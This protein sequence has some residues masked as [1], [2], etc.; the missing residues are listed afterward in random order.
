MVAGVSLEESA[1]ASNADEEGGGGGDL[2]P[3]YEFEDRSNPFNCPASNG[4][5]LEIRE[6]LRDGTDAES[7]GR[8]AAVLGEKTRNGMLCTLRGYG[9]NRINRLCR[10][11]SAHIRQHASTRCHDLTG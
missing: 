11:Y 1:R 6:F 8:T 2:R 5:H 10:I 4:I 7:T 9:L 3:A